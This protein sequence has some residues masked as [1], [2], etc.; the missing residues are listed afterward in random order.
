MVLID[1][2]PRRRALLKA[3]RIERDCGILLAAPPGQPVPMRN[4]PW[5]SGPDA[6][7]ILYPGDRPWAVHTFTYHEVFHSVEALLERWVIDDEAYA[8]EQAAREGNHAD[9]RN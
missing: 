5:Q 9:V 3:S 2:G 7:P 1:L 8:A 6:R 4:A